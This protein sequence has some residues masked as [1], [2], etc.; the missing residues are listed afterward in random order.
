MAATIKQRIALDGG[1][2]LKRELEEFGAAG[3]KAFRDLQKAAAETKG[4]PSGFFNSLK[5][6]EVQLKSLAKSFEDAGKRIQNVGRT[7]TTSLTL[8][9]VGI[10]AGVL[11]QAADFQTAM[12]SFAVNAGVAGTALEDARAKAQE[13]GQVSVFSS[14]EAA[15]GMTELAKVGL[16]F[17]TIME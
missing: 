9:I 10:G 1:K 13:L 4:L 6:A 12:N 2:E 16:D 15:E 11:K 8:P 5:Q 14:T 7:L 17:Q 3:R